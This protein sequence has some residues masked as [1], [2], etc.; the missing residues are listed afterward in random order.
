MVIINELDEIKIE[1]LIYTIR[2]KQVMLDKD[3][4]V[5]YQ[6]KNGTKSI[7]LAVKRNQERF[8]VD[9]CFQLTADE[10]KIIWSRFQNETLNSSKFKR[11]GNLK[12]LPYVFTE[13]GVAML[14]S[15]LKT[16]IA[17]TI[18]VNIMRAFVLMRNYISENLIEQKFINELVLRHE[19]DIKLLQESFDKLSEKEVK[20]YIYF[21]GQI[22]DSYS[23]IVD[24]MNIAKEELIIIDGYS[25]KVVLDMISKLNVKIIL[26]TKTKTKLSRLD[27]EKYNKQY[28]NLK[29]IYD[30]TFHD[31]YFILDRKIVYH[32]GTSINFIGNKTFSINKLEDRIVINSL[33]EN[34]S[35]KL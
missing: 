21:D 23:K 30:D 12:Y 34:V 4:A 20:N 14:S 33:L 17:T 15:V 13:E 3:L 22:Y 35:A 29:I 19:N 24:I 8:P 1:N 9:F 32:L 27:I 5:L 10:C 26:I 31:R 7:N 11:G 28:N 25:D 18:S 16:E 2:G 6:C